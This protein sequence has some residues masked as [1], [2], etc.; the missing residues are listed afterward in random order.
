MGRWL[1]TV[2]VM[3]LVVLVLRL[4]LAA[5]LE[6]L[7]QTRCGR[8]ITRVIRRLRRRRADVVVL[9]RP[10]ERV[11]ADLRRLH[12]SF[13]RGQ[14]P[15]AKYEGCRRAYEDVLAEAAEMMGVPH[16]LGVLL[17]GAERDRERARVEGLLRDHGLLPPLWAA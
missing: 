14:M 3:L 7:D 16:L 13:H 5:F 10:I 1:V 6:E 2:G 9:H 12:D 17:P 11:C 4:G 8:A 15:F